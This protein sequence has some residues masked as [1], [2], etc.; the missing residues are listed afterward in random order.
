MAKVGKN[1]YVDCPDHVFLNRRT[2]DYWFYDLVSLYGTTFEW[3]NLPS[4]V[5]A[6][7]LEINMAYNGMMV[8]F[9]D[10][11]LGQLALPF[12]FGGILNEYGIPIQRMAYGRNTY[13]REVYSNDSVIIWDNVNHISP[14]YA[15]QMYARRLYTLDRVIDINANAQK[16]PLLIRCT[17]NQRLTLKNVFEQYQGNSPA[18]FGEKGLDIDSL[19]A[20]KLDAPFV[21]GDL[22]TLKERYYTEALAYMGLIGS[23]NV[24]RERM[25]SSETSS[26]YI[27]VRAHRNARLLERREAAKKI[28]EMF[29]TNIE[30]EFRD[31]ELEDTI[32]GLREMEI[33][34]QQMEEVDE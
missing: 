3:I 33:E 11:V 2:Y 32:T 8:Y 7:F 17:E 15:L 24:K 14:A 16:N 20:I 12:T 28:N 19:E 9:E 6:R 22:Q 25:I 34:E 26:N 5:D 31:I 30:V 10:E 23:G 4:S 13:R 29:G 18:I 27:N 21:G 1:T